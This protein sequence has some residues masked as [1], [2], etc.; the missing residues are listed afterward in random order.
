VAGASDVGPIFQ[1]DYDYAVARYNSDGSLDTSFNGTGKVTTAIGS[2]FDYG[3]AVVMQSDGKIVV[4]GF[5]SN[6]SNDDFSAVRY[7][8]NGSLD[9]SFNGTGKVITDFGGANDSGYSAAIQ[10][11]GKILVAGTTAITTNKFAVVRYNSNGSLDTSFNG[12]GKVSTVIGGNDDEALSVIVQTDGKILA[13]GF[14]FNGATY[15]FAVVR[16]NSNGSLDTS[17]NGTG[18][19]TTSIGT[20]DDQG[21]SVAIQSDG[22]I[23]VAGF[24][25]NGSNYDFAVVRY[26]SNG[27]LDTSFN[28]TGKV[29]TDL[30]NFDAGYSVALQSDGKI[31]VGGYTDDTVEKD[32]AVVRYNSN[33][34]LDTSFSG[35]GKVITDV[36]NQ[37]VG[38]SMA[39]Q[40]D[41]KIVVAGYTTN[42]NYDFAV[43]R[44]VGVCAPSL[45]L[46]S[47]V[48]RKSHGV[49]GNFD[50][51][52]PLTGQPGVECRNAGAGS[53]HTLIFTFSNQIVS[54]NASVTS[55][56]G[57]VSGAPTFSGN[58]MTVNLTAVTNVQVLTVT[59]SGVTDQFSQVL[60]DTPVSVK[61]LLGDTTGNS[62]VNSS[63]IGLTKAKI[64]Q[65]VTASNF[66][67]D[68]S[69]NGAIN[70]SD[71]SIVKTHSGESAAK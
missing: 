40:A 27:S 26:N 33:G 69:V 38:Y 52:L 50:V 51:D 11:D 4:A 43:L 49:A 31:V 55:G 71:V 59:L 16:Y 19:V 68:V 64:G 23:V 1:P 17:F 20:S 66:R 60:P 53:S 10:S 21:H 36:D 61:L 47:A 14:S 57:N 35:T 44:Y 46:S 45:Q 34:S 3:Q 22:K 13:A 7:N 70:S 37:D 24:S 5:S 67:T 2:T 65:A 54:G 41:G 48:S 58:T 8:G 15:D 9:T 63:D 28:G 32:F 25:D 12:S 6:P 39:L 62:S 56:T 29:T 18:K 42:P 30:G